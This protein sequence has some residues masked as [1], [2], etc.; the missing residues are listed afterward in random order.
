M[1]TLHVGASKCGSS[2]IQAALSANPCLEDEA[3][4]DVI[5]AAIRKHGELITGANIAPDPVRG[6]VS[7]TPVENIQKLDDVQFGRLKTQLKRFRKAHL[8]LSQE[9][10]FL[11]A[12]TWGEMLERL[13]IEVNVVVYV[14]PQPLVLNSGWWQWGAWEDTPLDAWVRRRLPR[15]FWARH[16]LRWSALPRV[17]NTTVR[18]L[19]RDVVSDFLSVLRCRP[20]PGSADVQVNAGLPKEVLRLYQ[21]NRILRRHKDDSEIDF[22]LSKALTKKGGAPWVLSEATIE[23]VLRS[24]RE[25]NLALLDV[26]DDES[27]ATMKEDASWWDVDAYSG[28]Q[29]ESWEIQTPDTKELEQLCVDMARAIHRIM[30]GSE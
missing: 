4:K 9:S 11:S 13:D 24:S 14:R 23:H 8:V 21:R 29:L 2:A 18:L 15:A 26:L 20:L 10:W 19:P 6:Y 7:S 3:G 28:K 17:R 1:I 27:R 16:V 12:G 5:Y 30:R 25:D 22:A